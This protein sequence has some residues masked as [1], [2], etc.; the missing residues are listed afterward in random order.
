MNKTFKLK[1]RL[2]FDSL[3]FVFKPSDSLLWNIK[4]ACFCRGVEILVLYSIVFI[5]M[6]QIISNHIIFLAMFQIQ[7]VIFFQNI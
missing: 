1:M 4:T 3:L 2:D 7:F 6:H 5:R